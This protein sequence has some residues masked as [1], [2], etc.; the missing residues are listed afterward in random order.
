MENLE[1]YSGFYAENRY[2]EYEKRF[3][4]YA[5]VS[6]LNNYIYNNQVISLSSFFKYQ[7]HFCFKLIFFCLN[8]ILNS[9]V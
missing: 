2:G 5:T 7:Q 3:I 1:P 9:L 8:N 4:H 6:M